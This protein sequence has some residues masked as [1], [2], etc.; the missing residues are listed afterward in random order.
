M[1]L[2]LRLA[3]SL[4]LALLAAIT[5]PG[6]AA[7]YTILPPDETKISLIIDLRAVHDAAE[8][9]AAV[10]PASAEGAY[11]DLRRDFNAFI[12]E[13]QALITREGTTLQG[14]SHLDFTEL[15]LVGTPVIRKDL[16]AFSAAAP[17]TPSSTALVGAAGVTDVLIAKVYPEICDIKDSR[18]DQANLMNKELEAMKLAPW[19][20]VRKAAR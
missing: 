17:M 4:A 12:S 7:I 20:E 5:M 3:P 6:C 2:P 15:S 11:N 8:A 19:A 1:T 14:Y 18:L 16:E 9:T 13:R 10:A